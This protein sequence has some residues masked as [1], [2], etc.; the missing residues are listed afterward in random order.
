MIT[1]TRW[2]PA[3]LRGPLLSDLLYRYRALLVPVENEQVMHLYEMHHVM[4]HMPFQL[5]YQEKKFKSKDS[6]KLS[7]LWKPRRVGSKRPFGGPWFSF[8]SCIIPLPECERRK[9]DEKNF[10]IVLFVTPGCHSWLSLL[11]VTP[12]CHFDRPI[13]LAHNVIMRVFLRLPPVLP[14]KGY[15]LRRPRGEVAP[16]PASSP[17]AEK[18]GKLSPFVTLRTCRRGIIPLIH[19]G[20]RGVTPAC[21][22]MP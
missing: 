6:R 21:R 10:K 15:T 9:G 12:G 4:A 18:I 13:V 3:E 11:V 2:N 22:L 14:A 8:C 7:A 1:L 19:A 5:F 20:K 17:S 16:A